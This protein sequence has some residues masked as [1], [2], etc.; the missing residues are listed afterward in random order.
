MEKEHKS[1]YTPEEYLALEAVAETRNEYYQGEIFA[2]TGA[3]INHNR[4]V[5]N[6]LAHLHL[7]LRKPAGGEVFM[8]DMRVWIEDE[9]MFTYPDLSI[10]VEAPAFYQSRNDT[11]TNPA[12]LIE[13]LSDSTSDY[14]RGRKFECYRTLS[15]LKEYILVDQYKIHVEHFL[16]HDSGKWM[17]SEYKRQDDTLALPGIAFRIGLAD[18]YDKVVFE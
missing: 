12:I 7:A 3:S 5:N 17:M 6:L 18:I 15:S 13:V 9:A 2:M 8:N 11:I 14:D 16:K 4:I 10:L 1:I